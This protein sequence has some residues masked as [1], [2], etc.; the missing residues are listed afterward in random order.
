MKKKLT[1]EDA[2]LAEAMRD[3]KRIEPPNRAEFTQRQ[4]KASVRP[5]ETNDLSDVVESRFRRDGV[6][7]AQVKR[8]R[9][10]PI[11][12]AD[13]LDLHGHTVA[14]AEQRLRVFLRTA[15]GSAVRV[16]HGKG[17]GSPGGVPVLRD[18]VYRWL[19]GTESVLAFCPSPP[20]A[21]GSG[22]VNV[23]LKK[24]RPSS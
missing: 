21:G 16:I 9:N 6:Q 5:A 8:L 12:R 15:K 11:A 19:R 7:P 1:E 4:T 2:L 10:E 17:I 20:S 3:V 18:Q 23:L 13:E 14:E 24:K 22:A